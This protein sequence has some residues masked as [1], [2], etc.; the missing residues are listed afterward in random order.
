MFG[1]MGRFL[2]AVVVAGLAGAAGAAEG[3]A[4]RAEIKKSDDGYI[5]FTR[6]DLEKL[7]AAV[8]GVAP[9]PRIYTMSADGKNVQG[10]IVPPEFGEARQ[11]SFS[12]DYKAVVFTSNFDSARSAMFT[13]VFRMELATGKSVRLSGNESSAGAVKG[14]GTLYGV[15]QLGQTGVAADAVNIA[16]QGMDGKIFKLR[17]AVADARGQEQPGQYTYVVENVPAGKVW[18]KCWQSR[19]KGDLKFVD[20]AADKQNAAETMH[21]ADGNWLVTNPTISPDGRMAAVLSQHA[22][23]VNALP[24]AANDPKGVPEQGFDTVALL[25]LARGGQ[26]VFMWEPTKMRG[27]SAKDP[28]ISPDGKFVAFV[29]GSMP[30]E[31]LAVA[32]MESM[33]RGA[34]DVRVVAAGQQ[35]L[36]V[37][38]AACAA[39]AWS[40]DGKKLAFVRVQ[41]DLNMNFMGN[42]CVV[43]ADGTGAAQITK[44][45]LNQCVANPCWSPDGTQLAATLVTSKRPALNVLDLITLN[46]TSDVWAVKSDGTNQRQL[47][48]DGRSG[49]PA[50]GK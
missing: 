27:M 2:A 41:S 18:V 26:C 12:P 19:H 32:S 16:V 4:P 23:F 15:V 39:P 34:P 14:R 17:G 33:V 47:T 22:Y 24:G 31:S 9:I 43:N 38:A 21:L 45:A 40:P 50:W 44:V 10:F 46:V 29:A 3:L 1:R 28:R 37:G 20:V 6:L 13:D 42:L 25:D 7:P 11:A 35:A 8:G 48:R 36:G 49:E 5:L 30:A